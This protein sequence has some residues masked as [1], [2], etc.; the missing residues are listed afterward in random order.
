MK[1]T[2]TT[3]MSYNREWGKLH[4]MSSV[5]VTCILTA[6]MITIIATGVQDDSVLVEDGVPI[7][8]HAAAEDPSLESVL[9][10]I[11]NVVFAYGG[12]IAA[13]TLCSEMRKPEDFKKSFA[14]VQ[15]SQAVCYVLVGAI[16]Y[17]F[18][19]QYTVSPALTMATHTVSIIAY[20]FALVTIM[21]SGILGANVGTKYLYMSTLRHSTLLTSRGLKAW[22]AWMSMVVVMWIVGFI[23]SQLIPFFNELLT[24]ISSVFSVWFIYGYAGFMWFFDVHPWF[25]KYAND[26]KPRAVDTPMKK[27]LMGVSIVSVSHLYPFAASKLMPRSCSPL[28]SRLWVSTRPRWV[29]R[30]DTRKVPIATPSR[31][32]LLG[33]GQFRKLKQHFVNNR[34]GYGRL[35]KV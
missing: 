6:A 5:S 26:H 18:G 8:W 28:Q 34:A 30:R 1:G 20:A 23:V 13:F 14:V 10:G 7:E 17:S 31:A 21:V 12:S 27:L 15:G 24:V 35:G 16:V 2:L 4:L 19:G 33:E 32:R 9:G 29:S 3:Q 11:T 22:L 25:A